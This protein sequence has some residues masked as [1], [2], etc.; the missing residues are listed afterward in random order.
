[1]LSVSYHANE[2]PYFYL[3]KEKN[4][5]T[6]TTAG[7]QECTTTPSH[8]S[9]KEYLSICDEIYMPACNG[10]LTIPLYICIVELQ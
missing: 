9:V 4:V 7:L 3:G 2:N 6:A 10:G 1:L 5:Y 8:A